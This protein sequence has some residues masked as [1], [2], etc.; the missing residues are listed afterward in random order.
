MGEELIRSL[1]DDFSVSPSGLSEDI[2]VRVPSSF[3]LTCLVELKTSQSGLGF[4]LVL[5][6]AHHVI[7][8]SSNLIALVSTSCVAPFRQPVLLRQTLSWSLEQFQSLWNGMSKL[9]L[10]VDDRHNK[11][12]KSFSGFFTNL[13]TIL[14]P[15]AKAGYGQSS[16]AKRG[17]ILWV[18]CLS[19][20][21]KI[22]SSR[23]HKI[24]QGALSDVF[25]VTITLASTDSTLR[26]AIEDILIPN[27][28][29]ADQDHLLTPEFRSIRDVG[30]QAFLSAIP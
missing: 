15:A 18:Q 23:S 14:P 10:P 25:A 8:M 16:L 21:L 2:V 20:C 13:S 9:A 11:I 26:G 3:F 27:M 7:D 22:Y 28:H 12:G 6:G 19:E 1:E 30:C 5:S 17:S 29:S 24:I 4:D